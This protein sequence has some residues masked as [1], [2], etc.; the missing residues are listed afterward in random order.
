MEYDIKED[1]GMDP[2]IAR[3]VEALRAAGVETF[4]S[5]QGG[6]GHAFPYPT[7]RFRGDRSEGLR[8][9]ALVLQQGFQVSSLNRVWPVIDGEPTGPYW[10][11][12]FRP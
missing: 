10:E 9:L 5:C 3:H 12:E 2:G 4:E 6:D 7:V 11:L 8:A 1:H